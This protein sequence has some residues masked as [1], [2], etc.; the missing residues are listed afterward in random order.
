MVDVPLMHALLARRAAARRRHPRR[1]RR[2]A[3]VGR[4]GPGAGRHH[5][6]G[7][8]PRRPP[9]RG[10]PPGER[11]PHHRQRPPDQPR[12]DAGA[13]AG[14]EATDFYFSEVDDPEQGAARLLQIV[15]ERI[16]ARFGLDPVRDVQV[17]CPMNRGALGA[18]ALNLG[19]AEAAEPG[20][21]GRG[22]S[23][24]AGCSRVGDKVMQIEN[25]YD[26]DV[27]NGDLGFV[28]VDR[29]GRGRAGRGLRRPRRSCTSFGELD[30]LVL[31]YA[32]T[33]HKAQG[34]EYPAVVIP[35]STQHY[36]MLQR[37]LAL[38]RRHARPEAGR[39]RRPAEGAGD[40]GGRPA[41]AAALVE[42]RRSGCADGS[43]T[44]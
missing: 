29:R 18:R 6:L 3:A 21:T 44:A 16:P 39:A 24:S 5:R 4:P 8:G 14:G 22:S 42:A 28:I 31:A 13:G 30:R 32:T 12:R 15:R 9:H 1:R 25:D 11:E 33:I 7:R 37:N 34:S 26:K 40:R 38:H 23:G 43:S 17:L 2:P 20:A 10:V 36:P 19:A 27:Y 41:G 35:V